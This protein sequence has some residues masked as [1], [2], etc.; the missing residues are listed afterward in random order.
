MWLCDSERCCAHPSG[1]SSPGLR[2]LFR[3]TPSAQFLVLG[4]YK[5]ALRGNGNGSGCRKGV[6]VPTRTGGLVR[7]PPWLPT[8]PGILHFHLSPSGEASQSAG[9]DCGPDRKQNARGRRVPGPGHQGARGARRPKFS[10]SEPALRPLEGQEPEAASRPRL[11]LAGAEP[12]QLR[13]RGSSQTPQAFPH[14]AGPGRPQRAAA[15]GNAGV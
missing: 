1:C 14:L 10:C 11:M 8:S 12:Q 6:D 5:G 7:T 15:D 3:E 9:T 2:A 4:S 13:S